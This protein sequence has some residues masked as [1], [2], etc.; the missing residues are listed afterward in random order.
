MHREGFRCESLD[1]TPCLA[2]TRRRADLPDL[3][4]RQ[5]GMAA[6]VEAQVKYVVAFVILV[7]MISGAMCW[8]VEAVI[9]VGVL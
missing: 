6:A 2:A 4:Q 7:L 5:M 8:A 1:R 9:G 3:V